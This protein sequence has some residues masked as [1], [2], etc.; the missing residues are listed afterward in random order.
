M[1]TSLG[2][3]MQALSMA[4]AATIPRYPTAEMREM[5]KPE[6]KLRMLYTGLPLAG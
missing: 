6:R 2:R 1:M 3:G 5:I 4:M